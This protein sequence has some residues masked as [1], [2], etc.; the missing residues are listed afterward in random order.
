MSID[1][2]RGKI[3]NERRARQLKDYSGL[4]Y[5]KI[6][7]TDLD[8]IIEF[9]DRLFVLIDYKGQ[10]APLIGGQ[11][12]CFE[13]IVDALE[14]AGKV[15]VLVISDHYGYIGEAIDCANATVRSIYFRG[16]WQPFRIEQSVKQ[17]VDYFYAEHVSPANAIARKADK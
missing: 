15:S 1:E 7:P 12:K 6:T 5:D 17:V 11:R 8:G 13:R 14:S 10:D 3:Y 4:R 9:S 16:K 2:M